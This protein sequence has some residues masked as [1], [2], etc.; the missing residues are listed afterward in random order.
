MKHVINIPTFVILGVSIFCFSTTH[1]D[2]ANVVQSCWTGCWVIFLM[3]CF[4]YRF[5]QAKPIRVRTDGVM[6]TACLIGILE[7]LYT[8]L[9]LFDIVPNN[10]HYAYFAGSLNNPAVFG[11]LLSFLVPISVY[12]SIRESG[13][14]RLFGR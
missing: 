13:K 5:C 9:Q 8:I 1:Y 10:Y 6:K 11:M 3:T 7:I 12:Y 2:M 4:L 14:K